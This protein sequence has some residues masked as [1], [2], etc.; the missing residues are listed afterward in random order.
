MSAVLCMAVV[1]HNTG[2]TSVFL[3][4]DEHEVDR[5]IAE[6]IRG[7]WWAVEFKG[8]CPIP[9]LPDSQLVRTYFELCAEGE[10]EEYLEYDHK[11]VQGVVLEK[12]EEA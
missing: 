2:Q 6:C 12:P 1:Q 9:K 3:H 11:E 4:P 7:G 10:R 5:E 8:Q